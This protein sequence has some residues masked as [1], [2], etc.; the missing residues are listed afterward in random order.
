MRTVSHRAGPNA[1]LW[2]FKLH[3]YPI[4]L[5]IDNLIQNRVNECLKG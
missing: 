3:H 2:K 4:S 5:R 1:S